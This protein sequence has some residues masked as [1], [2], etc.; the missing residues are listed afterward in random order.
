[1]DGLFSLLPPEAQPYKLMTEIALGVILIVLNL[2][3]MKESIKVLLPIFLG[4]FLTHVFLILYGIIAHA[5]G[6]PRLIPDCLLYT[7]RCV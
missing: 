5:D 4:F 2:R 1:M 7:S 6:L 3:G